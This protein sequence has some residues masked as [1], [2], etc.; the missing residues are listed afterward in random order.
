MGFFS[1]LDDAQLG[2]SVATATATGGGRAET[3]DR[4][5]VAAGKRGGRGV[6][7]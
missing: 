4:P 7:A 1:Y 5:E 2:C 6:A 3:L